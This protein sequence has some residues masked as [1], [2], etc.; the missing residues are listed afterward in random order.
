MGSKIIFLIG[1]I[2]FLPGPLERSSTV[3][4]N[5]HSFSLEPAV[6]ALEPAGRASNPA[7]RASEPAGRLSK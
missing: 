4:Q 7:V 2:P 6:R 1:G 5:Y 3:L